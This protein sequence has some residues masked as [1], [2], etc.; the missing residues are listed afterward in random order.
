MHK[1]LSLGTNVVKV[2]SDFQGQFVKLNRFFSLFQGV[3]S[4]AQTGK[5]THLITP[6]SCF[7]RELKILLIKLNNLM[8]HP[9]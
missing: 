3:I 8:L 2:T 9:A 5:R 7:A 6:P 1:R 4:F